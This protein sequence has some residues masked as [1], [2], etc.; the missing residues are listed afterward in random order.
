MERHTTP[1]ETTLCDLVIRELN[2]NIVKRKTY[3]LT[4]DK[5]AHFQQMIGTKQGRFELIN[6]IELD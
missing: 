5:L 6:I 2:T 4:A 1:R 3:R